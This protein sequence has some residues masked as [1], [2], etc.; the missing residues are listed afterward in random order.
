MIAI[1]NDEELHKLSTTSLSP[2][3]V[4]SPPSTPSSTRTR[5]VPR[6][7]PLWS[8]KWRVQFHG[9]RCF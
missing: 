9:C 3:L 8:S 4:S 1:R 2:T 5:R 7:S 6:M